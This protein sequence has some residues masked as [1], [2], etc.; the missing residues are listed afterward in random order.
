MDMRAEIC[1]EVRPARLEGRV[2]SPRGAGLPGG[3][4]KPLRPLWGC[5]GGSA[6]VL[7]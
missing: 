5:P 3:R 1:D 2:R 4:E 6:E 7:S